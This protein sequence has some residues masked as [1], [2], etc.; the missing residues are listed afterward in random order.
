MLSLTTAPGLLG[1]CVSYCSFFSGSGLMGR[2]PGH[3]LFWPWVSSHLPGGDS[4]HLFICSSV[5]P[6][7]HPF[8]HLSIRPSPPSHLIIH[9]SS[10]D[11]V[12]TTDQQLSSTGWE[13]RVGAT[14]HAH[15]PAGHSQGTAGGHA[16]ALLSTQASSGHVWGDS[17]TLSFPLSSVVSVPLSLSCP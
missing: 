7:N 17:K 9:L 2:P 14:S 11:W 1:M 8:V 16:P 15:S 5:Y 6:S 10:M 3:S 13:H 4:T 12:P